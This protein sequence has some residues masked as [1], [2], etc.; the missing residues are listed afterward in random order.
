MFSDGTRQRLRRR[1]NAPGLTSISPARCAIFVLLLVSL[2]PSVCRAHAH[3]FIDYTVT[4]EFDEAGL[5]GMRT[6]WTFDRMF[7]SFIIKQFDKDNNKS[8]D[9]QEVAAIRDNAFK[10]LAKDGYFAHLSHGKKALPAPR[11]T[12]FDAKLVGKKDVVRYSFFLPVTVQ[13][14]GE[15]QRVSLFFFDPVIYVSFTITNKD[16]SI[17]MPPGA[18]DAGI[19]L[20]KVKYTIR[21]TVSFKKGP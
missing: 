18:I 7:S 5:K 2:C 10:A 14:D 11:P 19:E 4:A 21:P 13:A 8:F 12:E 15:S 16:V 20:N 3:I 17:S 6:V 1:Y 9:A